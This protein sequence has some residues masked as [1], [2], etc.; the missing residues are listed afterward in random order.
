MQQKEVLLIIGVLV[1]GLFLLKSSL[2]GNAIA[3]NNIISS[4][5]GYGLGDPDYLE[6][7]M[8]SSTTETLPCPGVKTLED[9]NCPSWANRWFWCNNIQVPCHCEHFGNCRAGRPLS[10]PIS[11]T[12]LS[13]AST[14]A[15]NNMGEPNC[16]SDCTKNSFFRSYAYTNYDSANPGA[17]EECVM[18]VKTITC[19]PK[20]D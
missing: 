10:T 13:A 1:V 20:D 12:D 9:I 3:G 17:T 4:P 16:P 7:S 2:S 6:H 15:L 14:N 5:Q 8:G 19:T 11:F 18:V